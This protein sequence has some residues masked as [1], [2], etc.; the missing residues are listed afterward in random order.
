MSS[1]QDLKFALTLAA[2]VSLGACATAPAINAQTETPADPQTDEISVADIAAPEDRT[3]LREQ[4]DRS[5]PI[6]RAN[7]WG[8]EFARFPHD[9]DVTLGFGESLRAIGSHDRAVEVAVE[10]AVQ[11][12]REG[13]IYLLMGRAYAGTGKFTEARAALLRAIMLEPENSD[14]LAALGLAHDRL[15]DHN[16]AQTAYSQA[17]DLDA[18]RMATWSNYGLSLAMSGDL[19]GAES[20]LRKAVAL[21]EPSVQAEQNLALVLGLQGRYDEMMQVAGDAPEALMRN[22]VA[23]LRE[24]RGE[25]IAPGEAVEEP[26]KPAGAP[27]LRGAI[28]Q[29]EHDSRD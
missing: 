23:L 6:E 2:L 22:N 9:I 8:Q 1:P 24:M 3:Q 4:A 12:P 18:N 14:I 27:A 29:A 11:H 26:G 19:K 17:L 21:P 13:R 25:A 15:G 5:P 7:F 28:G 20:A 16:S 10:A